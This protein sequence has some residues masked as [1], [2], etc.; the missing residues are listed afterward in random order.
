MKRLKE[1][2]FYRYN[3][4]PGECFVSQT[5]R[6]FAFEVALQ[7]PNVRSALDKIADD[8][9]KDGF[10]FMQSREVLSLSY[11]FEEQIR[12]EWIPCSK[13]AIITIAAQGVLPLYTYQDKKTGQKVTICPHYE[14]YK[15]SLRYNKGRPEFRFWW[16][17]TIPTRSPYR[18]YVDKSVEVI[19]NFGYNP[20]REGGLNSLVSC[21]FPMVNFIGNMLQYADRAEDKNTDP[22]VFV[23]EQPLKP[24]DMTSEDQEV[25]Y[26]FYVDSDPC[27]ERPEDIYDELDME[28]R[29]GRAAAEADAEAVERQRCNLDSKQKIVTA[30]IYNRLKLRP[31][32]SIANQPLPRPRGDL[33]NLVR[34][35][36]ETVSEVFKIPQEIFSGST[37]GKMARDT[38]AAVITQYR[39]TLRT[40]AR[41]LEPIVT[42]IY[43]SMYEEEDRRHFRKMLG[44][45]LRH[46]MP[47]LEHS[48]SEIRIFMNVSQGL[49][50][51]DLEYAVNR[52]LLHYKTMAQQWLIQNGF[53]KELLANE[54]DI[55]SDQIKKELL[56]GIQN[57][58]EKGDS[59][60]Q[61]QQSAGSKEKRGR[62][63]KEGADKNKE[64]KKKQKQEAES[65]SSSSNKQQE[66]QKREREKAKK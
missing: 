51:A 47:K 31:G 23:A 11:E 14:T 58:K 18:D 10:L 33:V 20:G 2:G 57:K 39:E 37:G 48:L 36:K 46:L 5:E 49:S 9:T 16:V 44:K 53:P 28:A 22:T 35:S 32:E 45:P 52:G 30:S 62:E 66:E 65:S 54:E 19:H 61:Q 26:N 17:H 40:W 29:L 25:S 34:I 7:H 42:F 12:Q 1:T 27:K 24:A 50:T 55:L 6:M 3:L 15:L 56:L 21:L 38:T 60:Q 59:S 8:L 4:K 41:R 63:E 43:R 64:G 13:Y